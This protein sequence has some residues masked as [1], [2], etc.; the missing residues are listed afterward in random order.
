MRSSVHA[1]LF[2]LAGLLLSGAALGEWNTELGIEG[3]WHWQSP[4]DPAQYDANLSLDLLSEYYTSWDGGRQSFL[5][6]PF[7]RL[8]QGD[9]KRTHVDLREAVW[10]R[11]GDDWEVRA[12]IDKVFWGVTESNHLVD[13]VNQTDGL[14]NPD[15][16]AKLGQPMLKLSLER[17][18]GTLDAFFMPWFRERKFAGS[19]GRLRTQPRVDVDQSVIHSS[20][21]ERYPSVAVRWSQSL[22]DWDV[23]LSHFHGISREPRFVGGL[24]GGG[25]PVLIPHYDV[26]DQSGMDLQ[27]V[28]GDWL[29]KLELI[30]RSGQ[31]Q[32]FWAAV[33]GFEYTLV[34]IAETASD[35][36]VLMEVS[37]D[38]RGNA[39]ST[40]NNHDVFVGLRWVAN[41]EPGTEVLAGM[42]VDWEYG[43]RFLNVEASRRFG[44]N[45]KASLQV[46]AW[47]NVDSA[48]P[49]LAFAQ[50][51]YAELRLIRY[52]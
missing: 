47:N 18:W 8:D 1:K 34:G 16:E 27:A 10:T 36:G 2:A 41:D 26:I 20:L 3:R 48:D 12:G 50:D 11:V 39:A 32:T 19:E 44:E 45:W 28:K 23:G 40:P 37:Y 17:E 43:S 24:D 6:K 21:K 22:G 35:L 33:G 29:W 38:D 5:I 25:N 30:H 31:A 52:F 46:R 42:S 51:D 49:A 14:E 9:S 13:V 7:V 4:V 15:G